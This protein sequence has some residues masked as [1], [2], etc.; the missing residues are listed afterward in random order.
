M[1]KFSGCIGKRYKNKYLYIFF[2]HSV[3]ISWVSTMWIVLALLIFK[4]LVS[5]AKLSE[6]LLHCMFISSSWA[7]CVVDVGRPPLLYGTFWTRIRKS[8]GTVRRSQ[9]PFSPFMSPVPEVQTD[10]FRQPHKPV[11]PFPEPDSIHIKTLREQNPKNPRENMVHNRNQ[12]G[13]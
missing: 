11:S 9:V 4:A 3:H 1:N 10:L 8:P 5:F 13:C 7:R 12:R 2:I 6:P